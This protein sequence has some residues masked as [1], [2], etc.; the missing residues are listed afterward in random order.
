MARTGDPDQ[1]AKAILK[2]TEE[3]DKD[4]Y[5][6]FERAAKRSSSEKAPDQKPREWMQR[7]INKCG[8]AENFGSFSRTKVDKYLRGHMQYTQR[9]QAK[10]EVALKHLHQLYRGVKDK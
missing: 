2:K 10:H 9:L 7:V 8:G 3:I 4:G 1:L 6:F 5:A